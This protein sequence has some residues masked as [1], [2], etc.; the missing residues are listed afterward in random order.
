MQALQK[1]RQAIESMLRGAHRSRLLRA[2]HLA[3]GDASR[4]LTVA[5]E[6]REDCTR[7]RALRWVSL[8][9]D[10][11]ASKAHIIQT[12]LTVV[13]P[14]VPGLRDQAEIRGVCPTVRVPRRLENKDCSVLNAN[15][16]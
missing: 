11:V 12:I 7:G 1:G 5:E 14:V 8:L 2:A 4:R 9:R 13:L 10:D 6:E 15:C 3:D 16:D